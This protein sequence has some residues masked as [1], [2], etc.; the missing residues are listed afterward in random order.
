MDFNADDA[1]RLRIRQAQADGQETRRQT[2]PAVRGA[3]SQVGQVLT[4][5][6][7]TGLK[8]FEVQAYEVTGEESEGSDGTLNDAGWS[9]FATNLGSTAPEDGEYILCTW[10]DY[11]WC[12]RFDA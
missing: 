10:C 7:T 8:V 9:F 11:R 3:P 1:E 4:S 12:F 2:P 5:S 6:G